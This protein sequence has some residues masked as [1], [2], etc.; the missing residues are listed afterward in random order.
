MRVEYLVL[1]YSVDVYA[2][3]GRRIAVIYR[4]LSSVPTEI[5]CL[6]KNGWAAEIPKRN[7]SYISGVL[8]DFKSESNDTRLDAWTAFENS[9]VGLLRAE[10]SGIC[11]DT[12]IA[13]L[14][15]VHV[16]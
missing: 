13:D 14:L 5:R 12:E 8:T 2:K 11:E 7:F 15:T 16:A 3:V 10:C 4:Q 9:S 6:I 1:M